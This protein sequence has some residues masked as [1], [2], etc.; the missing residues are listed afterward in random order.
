MF[1][2]SNSVLLPFSWPRQVRGKRALGI[3][4]FYFKACTSVRGQTEKCGLFIND[5][6]R[7]HCGSI[8][9]TRTGRDVYFTLKSR[10]NTSLSFSLP[11]SVSVFKM[12]HSKSI[13]V[14]LVIWM[15]NRL[16][17]FMEIPRN[18]IWMWYNIDIT[19]HHSQDNWTMQLRYSSIFRGYKMNSFISYYGSRLSDAAVESKAE[20]AFI[21]VLSSSIFQVT[22]C[23]R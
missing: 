20:Y 21:Y 6:A 7:F 18:F 23:T 3:F 2:C 19:S 22:A 8:F 16:P 12:H 1:H 5:R 10:K 11:L 4:L 15:S 14:A 17:A 9:H 13:I